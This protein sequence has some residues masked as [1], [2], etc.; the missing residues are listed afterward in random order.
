[1]KKTSAIAIIGLL[2]FGSIPVSTSIANIGEP[3]FFNIKISCATITYPVDQSTSVPANITIQWNSTIGAVDYEVQYDT[4]WSYNSPGLEDF[5][6]VSGTSLSVSLKPNT[7]YYV[8]V[9]DNQQD[10]ETSFGPTVMFTT[11]S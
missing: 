7:T 8:H 2:V 5:P 3:I 9:K 6:H 11:G 10:T 4:G 1:M